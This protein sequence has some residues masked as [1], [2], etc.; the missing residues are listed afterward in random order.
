MTLA[1]D[2][3]SD[4]LVTVVSVYVLSQSIPVL[5]YTVTILSG[6]TYQPVVVKYSKKSL[7]SKPIVLEGKQACQ[8]NPDPTWSLLVKTGN[9]YVKDKPESV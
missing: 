6:T 5:S 1:S 9:R 3:G 7:R 4:Q 2:C 8:N